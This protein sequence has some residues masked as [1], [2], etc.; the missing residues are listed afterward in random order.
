[1]KKVL[2][3]FICLLTLSGCGFLGE[4]R[5]DS[6]VLEVII[7]KEE[8][9]YVQGSLTARKDLEKQITKIVKRKEE[10]GVERST[11]V[12]ILKVNE[13]A[14]MGTVADIRALLEKHK[15]TNIEYRTLKG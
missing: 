13:N 5:D 6:N 14:T 9:F 2:I 1:M 3:V 10:S 15:L 4:S 7:N 8:K 12:V 11:V